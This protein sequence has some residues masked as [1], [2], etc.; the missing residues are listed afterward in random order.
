MGLAACA[1]VPFYVAWLAFVDRTYVWQNVSSGSSTNV[2]GGCCSA[3]ESY[4]WRGP[5]ATAQVIQI[6][7]DAIECA[8]SS[9]GLSGLSKQVRPNLLERIANGQEDV[10]FR[11]VPRRFGVEV[12]QPRPRRYAV[13]A[14]IRAELA[15]ALCQ[16]VG[17]PETCFVR[18]Q[19][20]FSAAF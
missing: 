3:K 14:E 11:L 2:H 15:G 19:D 9:G 8:S 17:D 7:A 16:L 13:H 1:D 12:S 10:R 4:S 18:T 6:R 20:T 5:T